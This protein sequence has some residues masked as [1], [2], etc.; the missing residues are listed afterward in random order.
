MNPFELRYQVLN[1]AKEL[2]EA[3]FS[4]N[5]HCWE[6]A[7]KVVEDMPKPPTIDQVLETALKMNKFISETK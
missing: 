4:F 6:I 3:Q 7:E 1:T 5:L 2:L